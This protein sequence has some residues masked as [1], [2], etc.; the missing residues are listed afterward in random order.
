MGNTKKLAI[1]GLIAGAAT[2]LI[3]KGIMWVLNMLGGI[4]PSVSLK[5]ASPEIAVN[6]RQSLTGLDGSLAGWFMDA[7]GANVSIG[8]G[9]TPYLYGAIGGA[10][11]FIGA[12]WL[13]D[14]LG[15]LKGTALKKTTI[16]IFVGNLTL[17]AIFGALLPA[18]LGYS[19]INVLIAF[20]LNAL[21]L[22]WAYT[23]FDK[24]ASIGLVP[25]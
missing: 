2:P 24:K 7:I 17:G 10:L 4:V 14:T 13:S 23:E 21:I 22:A 20:A 16:M 5:L 11:L 12:D 19:F 1:S 3:L 15:L 18:S 9:L 6:V 25:Y 8:A